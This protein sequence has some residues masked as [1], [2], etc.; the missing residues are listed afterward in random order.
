[1]CDRQRGVSSLILVKLR[2]EINQPV[3]NAKLQRMGAAAGGHGINDI[4]LLC[5]ILRITPIEQCCR[6]ADRKECKAGP[7]RGCAE[8]EAWRRKYGTTK[9]IQT[10]ASRCFLCRVVGS[11]RIQDLTEKHIYADC[12]G[13]HIGGNSC[14][15]IK[16][17]SPRRKLRWGVVV[18]TKDRKSIVKVVVDTEA[19]S[20]QRS[21]VRPYRRIG[22]CESCW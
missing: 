16:T 1:M 22:R 18:S 6:S 4:E 8:K 11:R 20:V 13:L 7:S 5:A 3:I 19:R 2:V 14:D 17:A 12:S 10:I 15:V 9:T 21:L